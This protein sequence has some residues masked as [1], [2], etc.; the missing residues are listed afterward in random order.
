MLF[1]DCTQPLLVDIY[2]Y[3]GK[4]IG[5]TFKGQAVQD[6]QKTNSQSGGGLKSSKNYY[7]CPNIVTNPHY[8]RI[9]V[10]PI[11]LLSTTFKLFEKSVLKMTTGTMSNGTWKK[12]K[13]VPFRAQHDYSKHEA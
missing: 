8:R 4:N 5:T 12:F 10:H 3:F 1:S 7:L 13:P 2:W 11:N 6:E 9:Y